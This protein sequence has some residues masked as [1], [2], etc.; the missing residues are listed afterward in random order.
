MAKAG[1][2]L[3]AATTVQVYNNNQLSNNNGTI[4]TFPRFPTLPLL[5]GQ[6][7]DQ[8]QAVLVSLVDKKL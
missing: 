4:L 2:S 7:A 3:L 1:F 6:E 5:G 8:N